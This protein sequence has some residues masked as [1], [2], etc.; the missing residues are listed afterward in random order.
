MKVV[1]F[2]WITSSYG[3]K[4]WVFCVL[5]LYL[6]FSKYVYSVFKK[7]KASY[8]VF[9]EILLLIFIVQERYC[10]SSVN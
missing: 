8:A 9:L 10:C 1:N 2:E 7:V 4:E 5:E 6:S 3:E